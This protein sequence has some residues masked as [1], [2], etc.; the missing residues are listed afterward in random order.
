MINLWRNN[1]SATICNF[2]SEKQLARR[3]TFILQ[4]AFSRFVFLAQNY[5]ISPRK[6]ITPQVYKNYYGNASSNREIIKKAEIQRED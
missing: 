5:F 6:I 1:L 4:Y 3:H 2:G